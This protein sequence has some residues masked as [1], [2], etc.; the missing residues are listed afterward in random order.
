M[1]SNPV[2]EFLNSSIGRARKLVTILKVTYL[3]IFMSLTMLTALDHL[4]RS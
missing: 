2:L 3:T 4:D 1:G